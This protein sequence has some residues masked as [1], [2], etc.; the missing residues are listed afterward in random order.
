MGVMGMIYP[1]EYG[2]SGTD[3]ISYAIAIEEI[4]KACATTGC[5]VAAH[6]SLLWSNFYFGTKE[7]KKIPAGFVDRSQNRWFWTN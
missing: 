5:I 2:G 1:K 7:Q 3:S 6:S 4:S